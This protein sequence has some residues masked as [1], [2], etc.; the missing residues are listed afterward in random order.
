MLNVLQ[1]QE[2]E[3]R[4]KE[5][6]D[7][8]EAEERAR[9]A[10]RPRHHVLDIVTLVGDAEPQNNISLSGLL[11]ELTLQPKRV[12]IIAAKQESQEAKDVKELQEKLKG[13][14][15]VSR[16]KVTED[17]IY[18]AAYHPEVTKDLVFFGDKHG[19]LGIWDARAPAVEVEDEDGDI[20]K[21]DENDQPGGNYWRLQTH[22][23]ATSKSSISSVKFS[24]VDS[25][26]VGSLIA[27]HSCIM[28]LTY[29]ISI[30][31]HECI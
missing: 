15:V 22:W 7:A 24:P 23:P 29:R 1:A 4:A 9:A 21:Q 17:R 8:I 26:S 27:T 16:A 30:G 12:G 25:H 13:L 14:K 6:E 5:A 20:S 28:P 11:S 18:S 31:L 10:K 19:Q 3:Q 2:Q